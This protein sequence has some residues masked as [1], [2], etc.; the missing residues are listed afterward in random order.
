MTGSPPPVA[1]TEQAR[2]AV[3]LTGD[4]L[5][6]IGR[7]LDAPGF[8]GVAGSLY[9]IVAPEL[10][11]VLDGRFIATLAARGLVML[12][13]D[14]EPRP[15]PRL[16]AVIEAAALNSTYV[17]VWEAD[18]QTYG[19]VA[20]ERGILAHTIAEP[21]HELRLDPD[22]TDLTERLAAVLGEV[23][24]I[25]P[26][27]PAPG[28]PMR[29]PV[30]GLWSRLP[31]LIHPPHEVWLQVSVLIRVDEVGSGVR[32]EGFLAVLDGGAGELWLV[33]EDEWG[34]RRTDRN[35]IAV[36]ASHDDVTAAIRTFSK[37]NSTA[38]TPGPARAAGKSHE[39][40]RRPVAH[41]RSGRSG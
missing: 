37:I 28:S 23:L 17:T 30:R 26:D 19:F 24:G 14:G 35:V 29:S 25:S 36:P 34:E 31:E 33:T 4:E 20:G 6:A 18:Q 10:R 2:V 39:V 13:A 5:T 1:D 41:A 22:P 7:S 8:P 32:A 15:A 16:A 27:E 12:D 3:R 11:Q 40:T 9:D 21:L 38:A